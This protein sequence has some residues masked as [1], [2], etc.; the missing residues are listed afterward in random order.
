MG[1]L[2]IRTNSLNWIDHLQE[3]LNSRNSTVHSVTKKAPKFIWKPE[4]EKDLDVQNQDVKTKLDNK[5]IQSIP[6]S[7][8]KEM[9]IGDPVRIKLSALHTKVRALVKS[10]DSKKV[11]VKYSPQIYKIK[12]KIIPTGAKRD[13]QQ[14]RY[15]LEDDQHYKVWDDNERPI[16]FYGSDLQLVHLD[17]VNTLTSDDAYRLN[18]L[19]LVAN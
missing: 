17:T 8:G 10:G 1:D 11:I 15:I 3:I 13:F 12:E 18:K 14:I 16:K 9:Y 7:K 5:I 4:K 19:N 6:K 2:F